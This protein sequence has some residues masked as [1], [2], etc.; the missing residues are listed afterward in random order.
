MDGGLRDYN[1]EMKTGSG[2][3]LPDLAE[4][5]ILHSRG[6]AAG[7]CPNAIFHPPSGISTFVDGP[8]ISVAFTPGAVRLPVSIPSTISRYSR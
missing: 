6:I 4:P 5:S 7:T 2:Q 8:V 3:A 1:G